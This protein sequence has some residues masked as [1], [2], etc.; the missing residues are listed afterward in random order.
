MLGLENA[1]SRK[2]STLIAALDEQE[3]TVEEFEDAIHFLKPEALQVSACIIS[4][5]TA[6]NPSH[7]PR[8]WSA[9]R[10]CRQLA[11]ATRVLS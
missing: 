10:L 8:L 1:E 7:A 11:A 4:C 5:R 6:L 3:I 2:A 9:H